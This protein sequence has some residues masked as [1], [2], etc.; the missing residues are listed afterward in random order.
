MRRSAH[1]DSLCQAKECVAAQALDE[2]ERKGTDT[3]EFVDAQTA[4]RKNRNVSEVHV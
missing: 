2:C 3:P 4:I 1:S